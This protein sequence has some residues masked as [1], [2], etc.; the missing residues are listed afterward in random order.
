MQ[1]LKCHLQYHWSVA[2]LTCL[3]TGLCLSSN[4]LLLFVWEVSPILA[5]QF[6]FS[7]PFIRS[8]HLPPF[9]HT[10][11]LL[12]VSWQPSDGSLGCLSRPAFKILLVFWQ[13]VQTGSWCERLWVYPSSVWM[14]IFC[15]WFVAFPDTISSKKLL[16]ISLCLQA[17]SN[18]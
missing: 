13:L 15:L 6:S 3:Y 10:R 4:E 16:P 2:V 5:W 14:S 17:C 12:K 18:F 7:S 11:C 1:E 9:C 8:Y